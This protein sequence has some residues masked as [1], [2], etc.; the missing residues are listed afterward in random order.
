MASRLA[1]C[2][3]RCGERC[4]SS[5][6]LGHTCLRVRGHHYLLASLGFSTLISDVIG[7]DLVYH[8]LKQAKKLPQLFKFLIAWFIYSYLQLTQ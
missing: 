8:T 2:L 3:R 6:G 7:A 1:L 5:F 4:F